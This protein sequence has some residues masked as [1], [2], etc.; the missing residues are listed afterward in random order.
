MY[1]TNI[2]H[3]VA[4]V[5]LFI[6]LI[7]NF[8]LLLYFLSCSLGDNIDLTIILSTLGFIG[9]ILYTIIIFRQRLSSTN[10]IN[11]DIIHVCSSRTSRY[12][13][14]CLSFL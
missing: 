12:Y 6:N 7:T 13:K 9:Y 1:N 10:A 5:Y 3:L 11:T 2:D 4:N 14:L 8:P